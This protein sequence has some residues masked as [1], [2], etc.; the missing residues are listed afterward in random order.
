MK[1]ALPFRWILPTMQLVI[2][3]VALWP[4]RAEI[5]R[6]FSKFRPSPHHVSQPSGKVLLKNG[7]LQFRLRPAT[8]GELREQERHDRLLTFP[9]ML[10]LPVLFLELPYIL[11]TPDKRGW[12]PFNIDYRVWNAITWPVVGSIFWYFGGRGLEAL[13]A[14]RRRLPEPRMTLPETLVGL[15]FSIGGL[16]LIASFAW[17]FRGKAPDAVLV[18][19]PGVLAIWTSLG[20]SIVSAKIVQFRLKNAAMN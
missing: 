19:I 5:T 7:E 14:A 11:S 13:L 20:V 12:V 1:A 10:N 15:I 6:E 2:C 3:A 9:M 17:E 8:E 18:D 16:L 4:V